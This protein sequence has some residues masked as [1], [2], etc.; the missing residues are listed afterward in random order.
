M[1]IRALGALTWSP[2]E[3]DGR[4][5]PRPRQSAR[6]AR[7][8]AARE[9]LRPDAGRSASMSAAAPTEAGR[10]ER[11]PAAPEI[12]AQAA[13]QARDRGLALASM[14]WAADGHRRL[15]GRAPAPFRSAR[16]RADAI[17]RA[18]GR[19]RIRAP[20]GAS[21]ARRR[22]ERSGHRASRRPKP[23]PPRGERRCARC[24]RRVRDEAKICTGAQGPRSPG[25]ARL[26]G[27]RVTARDRRER[28]RSAQAGASG[29]PI[30]SRVARRSTPG[31]GAC[32][33]AR[34][35]RG[36]SSLGERATAS[37]AFPFATAAMALGMQTSRP[38]KEV[39]R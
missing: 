22:P 20:R 33:R 3:R 24:A 11:V 38:R 4:R 32:V 13:Q 2:E 26:A 35:R 39:G 27:R 37:V 34:P 31:L 9:R 18:V 10:V 23:G 29:S 5:C 17:G 30:A 28:P 15:S 16:A 8:P 25:E 36:G 12:S 14:R 1:R 7:A 6:V 21:G 19:P